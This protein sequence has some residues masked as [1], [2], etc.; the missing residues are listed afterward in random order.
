MNN[1]LA[2]RIVI[3]TDKPFGKVR[4]NELSKQLH[5]SAPVKSKYRFNSGTS[6]RRVTVHAYSESEARLLAH[7]ELDRR[8]EKAGTE[9]PVSWALRRVKT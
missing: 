9:P 3:R 2:K 6:F 7:I 5:A 4:P 8:A 1:H